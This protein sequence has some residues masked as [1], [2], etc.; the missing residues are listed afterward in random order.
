MIFHDS[1]DFNY[2]KPFGACPVGTDI[3]LRITADMAD[4]VRLHVIDDCD[5][6]TVYEM[7]RDGDCSFRAVIKAEHSGLL[8]YFFD[9]YYPGEDHCFYGN[10]P[11]LMGGA[12]SEYGEWP[13]PYQI[14]VYEKTETPSWYKDGIM[15]QIFPDRFARGSDFEEREEAAQRHIT[16]D[17]YSTPV[18]IKNNAGEITDW[19]FYG[20]TL[21][22]IEE[23]I[24]YLKELGVKTIYLNPVFEARSNHRYDTADYMHIDPLLGT[25][26]DFERLCS[27]LHENGMRLMIDG[28]FSHVGSKSIYFR[29]DSPYYEWFDKNEDGSQKYWWGVKDLPEINETNPSFVDYICGNEGV[30]HKWIT[31]GA[32]G[33]RLDVADE[34]PDSFIVEVR[35]RVKEEKNDGVVLGEVWED[36]SNKISHGEK[37][38]YLMGSEL[39]SIMNY[40]LRSI[41]IDFALENID[42][43]IFNRRIMSLMENYPKE[44]FYSCMNLISSHDRRRILTVLYDSEE[45]TEM[46]YKLMFAL[47]GVPCIY[48]GD[49]AGL[50]G[51][52]DPENRAAYPWGRENE[53]ML[54][55]FKELTSE[56]G[57]H[58]ALRG[59]DLTLLELDR[60]IAAFTRADENERILVL[61]N[62]CEEEKKVTFEDKEF[63]VTPLT[64]VYIGI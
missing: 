25:D 9:V 31:K 44:I 23:K 1:H 60:D 16:D 35:K 7:Q 55:F 57:S 33:V 37:R 11:D 24:P 4:G 14:T 28:V 46:L 40:P 47:P 53:N 43:H 62:R 49:E 18:Y 36:A 50:K 10:N 34:L 42:T 54:S 5:N 27:A 17:W 64:T 3:E 38:K 13:K 26:E 51:L 20:G 58:S 2:R 22:G 41:L 19:V 32:D 39:D 52:A 48:Y 59:G 30:L 8:W 45:G 15:Y 29:E 6:D 63:A 12:G 21:R 61:A 56:Y